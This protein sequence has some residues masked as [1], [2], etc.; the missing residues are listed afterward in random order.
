MH[1]RPWGQLEMTE[2]H[3]EYF[4][5]EVNITYTANNCLAIIGGH[6]VIS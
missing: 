5:Y 2:G 4:Y 6:M 3:T 1:N